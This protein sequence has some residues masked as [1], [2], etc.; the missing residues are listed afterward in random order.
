MR[1]NLLGDAFAGRSGVRAGRP[2][3]PGKRD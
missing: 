2:K 3:L 1:W